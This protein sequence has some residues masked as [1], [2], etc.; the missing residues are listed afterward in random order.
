MRDSQRSGLSSDWETEDAKADRTLL[1]S[2]EETGPAVF[3]GEPQRAPSWHQSLQHPSLHSLCRHN[4]SLQPT[5]GKEMSL[6][7]SHKK[8]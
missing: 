8:T 3:T 4:G 7:L 5:E 6:A 1:S 2:T